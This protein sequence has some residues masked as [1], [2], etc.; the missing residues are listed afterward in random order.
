MVW[1]QQSM[2]WGMIRDKVEKAVR[3]QLISWKAVWKSVDV[4]C[5]L[6]WATDRFILIFCYVLS[7]YSSLSSEP[8]FGLFAHPLSW[9]TWTEAEK[10]P[11]WH[12]GPTPGGLLSVASFCISAS[13]W[14]YLYKPV[15]VAS[16]LP[17][18]MLGPWLR[19]DTEV[20]SASRSFQS[21]GAIQAGKSI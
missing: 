9:I 7:F 4:I 19:C 15:L 13:R 16:S 21:I 11:D 18:L 1:L 20:A 10:G 12:R 5:R 14:A 3:T 17:G 6:W 8:P 2:S